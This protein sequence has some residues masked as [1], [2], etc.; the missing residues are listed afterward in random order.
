MKQNYLLWIGLAL[1]VIVVV[2]VVFMRTP[3]PAATGSDITATTGT[4]NTGTNGTPGAAS[5]PIVSTT[6]FASVS[7]TTAVV[8]GTII[9][10]GVQTTYWFEYGATPAFGSSAHVETVA[11]GWKPVGA[12]AYITGLKP[13]TQYYFRL[14]AKNAYGTVYGSPY[15][16]ITATK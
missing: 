5:K 14:G 6:G 4:D 1:L 15:S 13:A 7:T 16:F 9:P 11:T 10:E 8:V 3:G 2:L 12:A